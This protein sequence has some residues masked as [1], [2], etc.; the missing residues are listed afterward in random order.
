MF[1]TLRNN[2]GNAAIV[3]PL[4]AVMGLIFHADKWETLYAA[5]LMYLTAIILLMLDDVFPNKEVEGQLLTEEELVELDD[6]GAV[7]VNVSIELHQH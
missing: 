3:L 5:I 4:T 6:L 7:Q 1:D 2:Y